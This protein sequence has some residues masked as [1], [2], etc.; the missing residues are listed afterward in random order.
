L[1]G[2]DEVYVHVVFLDYDSVGERVKPDEVVYGLNMLADLNIRGLTVVGMVHYHGWPGGCGYLSSTDKGTLRVW[3]SGFV[4]FVASPDCVKAWYMQDGEIKEAELI[5]G[6]FVIYGE[7]SKSRS[8][9]RVE[10]LYR[11]PEVDPVRVLQDVEGSL[12]ALVELTNQLRGALNNPVKLNPGNEEANELIRQ[13]VKIAYLSEEL[14]WA[15]VGMASEI[16]RRSRNNRVGVLSR[17]K[18]VFRRKESREASH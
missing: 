14:Q 12:K 2:D 1:R 8:V 15:V 7:F 13:L 11:V 17:I 9:S 16:I 6:D 5:E 3:P 18:G 4:A 10:P